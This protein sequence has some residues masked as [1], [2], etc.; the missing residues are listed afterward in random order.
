MWPRTTDRDSKPVSFSISAARW[1][2]F[3]QSN[4]SEI[5]LARAE[6]GGSAVFFEAVGELRAF[7]GDDYAE[8]PSTAVALANQFSDCS[9]SKEPRDENHVGSARDTAVGS[10]PTESRP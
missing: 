1:R 7:G 5:V 9:M 6:H 2:Q 4:V 10:D 8:I 3:R